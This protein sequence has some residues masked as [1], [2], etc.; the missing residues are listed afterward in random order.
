VTGD[1]GFKGSWL[2][3]LLERA[4]ARVAGFALPAE[5]R[6]LHARLGRPVPPWGHKDVR[7][8]G[9]LAE[10]FRQFQ[11]E[12]V[13]HLAAQPLVRR[14]Y[15][16]PME[17]F[18]VNVHGTTALLEVARRSPVTRA[19]VVVTSDK[20]YRNDGSG[21]PFREDD[22]LGGEDPYSASK[23]ATEIVAASYRRSF[24]ATADPPVGLATARAG[25]VLGGGDWAQDRIV[26][27]VVRALESGRPL[28]LRNPSAVRP[29][30][31]V[32]DV[33]YGYAVLAV[34]LLD[35]PRRG[36]GPWNFAPDVPGLTVRELVGR[37]LTAWE[38]PRPWPVVE[39]APEAGAPEAPIL[40]LDAGR[41][42]AVL[43][44]RP[45]LDLDET[46]RWTAEWYRD[47]ADGDS[48]Q[49]LCAR[50]LESYL[51]RVAAGRAP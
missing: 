48:A 27:D 20:C 26:P 22:P 6:S 38:A 16:E 21:R 3:L 13:L 31:H 9:A 8:P 33:C 43:G 50:Q 17:T 29:W 37:V 47:L 49:S 14:S 24:F 1:T 36:D 12:V 41:A 7:D 51:G 19:I 45:R 10:A 5:E 28:M 34:A 25:N 4:G 40:R 42:R 39:E 32:L 2:V 44:W 11:P 35:D 18:S 15:R 30:Q 46:V 23:A